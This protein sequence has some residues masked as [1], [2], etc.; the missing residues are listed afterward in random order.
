[1]S[2]DLEPFLNE[3]NGLLQKV[4]PAGR[5]ELA[6]TIGKALRLKNQNRI[7][8]QKEPDGSAFTPRSRA[9]QGKGVSRVLRNQEFTYWGERRKI[10]NAYKDEGDY[11]VGYDVLSGGFRRFKKIDIIAP[12]GANWGVFK[13]K[14]KIKAMFVKLRTA[15]HLRVRGTSE[16]VAIQFLGRAAAIA[17]SHHYGLTK[18][19]IKLPARR[20]L[21]LPVEDRELIKNLTIEHL[22]QL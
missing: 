13:G 2:D 8:A 20:L 10:V 1:M 18:G 6:G 21:G 7:K 5:R 4:S 12:S 3:L 16:D 19:K 22:A 11:V 15:K 14:G 9:A 17:A